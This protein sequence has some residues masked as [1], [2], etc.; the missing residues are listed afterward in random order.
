MFAA[1]AAVAAVP[2]F[3]QDDANTA[4]PEYLVLTN[5][6]GN[7][8]FTGAVEYGKKAITLTSDS[9]KV[10]L[11]GMTTPK[12]FHKSEVAKIS[13]A[14][15]PVADLFDVVW[16]ADGTAKDLG[17]YNLSVVASGDVSKIK[18]D[19]EN[20][21]GIVSPVFT[22]EY[23]APD[24]ADYTNGYYKA[25]YAS[26]AAEMNA[27]ITNGFTAETIFYVNVDIPELDD[28]GKEL[29]ALGD[30][31]CKPFSNTQS[32]GFGF[33]ICKNTAADKRC[34]DYMISVNYKKT[35]DATALTKG[36]IHAKT[37]YRV[38]G[39][40]YYH[41]ISVYNPDT[42]IFDFYV[43]GV[44]FSYN[45]AAAMLDGTY[46]GLAASS[47]ASW[48]G[49]G[50]DPANGS[51]VKISESGFPGRVVVARMYENPLAEDEVKLLFEQANALKK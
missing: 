50:A 12:R 19:S 20:P 32:A 29:T 11:K 51:G 46:C 33:N 9:I 25:S 37:D 31:E 8:V 5:A 35:A 47:A 10:Q 15:A 2:A 22:N 34:L 27:T 18:V 39:R 30:Y 6:N 49:I 40:K 14:N 16:N 48:L 38:E 28:A 42:K 7:R 17:K 24:A 43:N 1:M 26:V 44:K 45:T 41:C 36:Y 3:A 4:K 21:Y 13:V 23:G